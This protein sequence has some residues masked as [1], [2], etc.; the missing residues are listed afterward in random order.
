YAPWCVWCIKL[1]PTWEAF[2][3]EVERTLDNSL[4]VAKV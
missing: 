2:A 1:A 4:R 3:E